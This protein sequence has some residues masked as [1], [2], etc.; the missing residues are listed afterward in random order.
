MPQL[1]VPARLHNWDS[2]RIPNLHLVRWRAQ[3][4]QQA[5]PW[6]VCQSINH[7]NEHATKVGG[8][9][10]WY[11]LEGTFC[12]TATSNTDI[13]IKHS[14]KHTTLYSHTWHITVKNVLLFHVVFTLFAGYLTL[15]FT[16]L[17]K[18]GDMSQH[19]SIFSTSFIFTCNNNITYNNIMT[20]SIVQYMQY[21]PF[22]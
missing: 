14:D 13:N 9:S 12:P 18:Q 8:I 4:H 17:N 22:N 15:V 16:S 5:L 10:F 19:C 1:I 20:N 11:S 6:L 7:F 3:R 2:V 21:T